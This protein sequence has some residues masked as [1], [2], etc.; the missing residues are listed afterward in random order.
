MPSYDSIVAKHADEDALQMKQRHHKERQDAL[1]DMDSSTETKANNANDETGGSKGNTK[2][3]GTF[4]RSM[5]R[6]TKGKAK[7]KTKS[8][9][10]TKDKESEVTDGQETGDANVDGQETG[11]ACV[12]GQETGGAS[13]AS[14]TTRGKGNG[15]R[16]QRTGTDKANPRRTDT[17]AAD[18]EED[19]QSAKRM[20]K[21]A[22]ELA[23]KA[24]AAKPQTKPKA[25]AAKA[26]AA[27][28]QTK[29]KAV[30]KAPAAQ[31]QPKSAASNVAAALAAKAAAAKA[32]AK[33]RNMAGAKPKPKP[34]PGAK[35][36]ADEE[37]DE[38]DDEE[39]DDEEE[40]NEEN[41]ETKKIDEAIAAATSKG[42][43]ALERRKEWMR[44]HRSTI[45]TQGVRSAK[46]NASDKCP[47][48]LLSKMSSH[49]A[50][51]I[52]FKMWVECKEEWGRVM[53]YFKKYSKTYSAGKT[54]DRWMTLKQL[55]KH[56]GDKDLAKEVVKGCSSRPN[57]AL[58]KT[59]PDLAQQHM[60]YLANI[61]DEEEAG[62]EKGTETGLVLEGN[63][64]KGD[65]A[66]AQMI[67]ALDECDGFKSTGGKPEL[68]DAEKAAKKAEAE[69][70]KQEKQA[71]VAAD[72]KLR[73]KEWLKG[74][75]ND[76]TK[77]KTAEAE[78]S[79]IRD[80]DI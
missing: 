29:P 76:I 27:K 19:E 53:M 18:N 41:E 8:K 22:K 47:Q 17:S 23:A 30:P 14:K 52:L 62:W 44:F 13:A 57:K 55:E 35:S 58:A 75:S 16:T 9:A 56:L 1:A 74:I 6:K 49:A 68:T 79:S 73:A 31:T 65:E 25:P 15:K 21:D 46:S 63:V 40:N 61:I 70:K 28:P 64:A 26:P 3:S 59:D 36:K 77:F 42:K 12:D 32:V 71:A 38:E 37:E 5:G 4:V 39:E 10:K 24:P 67:T 20:R 45:A 69:A 2:G 60:Q 72:P 78:A 48:E 43:T 54:I 80:R 11:G 7:A 34:K 51:D 66:I 33:N 50:K